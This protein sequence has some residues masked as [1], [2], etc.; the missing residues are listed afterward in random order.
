M[1]PA[2]I[3]RLFITETPGKPVFLVLSQVKE[4]SVT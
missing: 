4:T 1:F 3:G 2:L